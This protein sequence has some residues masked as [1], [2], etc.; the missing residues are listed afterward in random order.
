M[1]VFLP[2]KREKNQYLDEIETCFNGFFY[3]GNIEEYHHSF[4]IVNIHWPEAIFDC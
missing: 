4:E 1:K 2:F 3:Y